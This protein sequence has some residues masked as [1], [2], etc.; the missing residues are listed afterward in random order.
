MEQAAGV[1]EASEKHSEDM[2]DSTTWIGYSGNDIAVLIVYM[3]WVTIWL[4][5]G[6]PV[7]IVP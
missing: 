4:Y 7:I 6:V 3:T 1:T 5:V 2:K